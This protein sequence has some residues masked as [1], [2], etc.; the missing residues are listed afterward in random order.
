MNEENKFN[1]IDE[2]GQDENGED[3]T[4][5]NPDWFGVYFACNF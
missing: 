3:I 1:W 2:M 4:L 5:P